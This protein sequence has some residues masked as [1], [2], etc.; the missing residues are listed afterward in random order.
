MWA[1]PSQPYSRHEKRRWRSRAHRSTI[2]RLPSGAS[3]SRSTS[4]RSGAFGVGAGTAHPCTGALAALR[5]IPA[6][7]EPFLSAYACASARICAV[8][9]LGRNTARHHI[10]AHLRRLHN[11][12][13][14]NV[15]GPADDTPRPPALFVD[16]VLSENRHKPCRLYRLC[17]TPACQ[18]LPCAL[19]IV[20]AIRGIKTFI[21]HSPRG[22]RLKG[23]E[24]VRSV[25]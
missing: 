6:P 23:T 19:P 5:H 4:F 12:A 22:A 20:C 16:P 21:A 3:V 13:S 7:P 18:A 9:G 25:W 1:L 17:A 10:L 15:S 8:Y 11:P 14:L 2:T 24:N